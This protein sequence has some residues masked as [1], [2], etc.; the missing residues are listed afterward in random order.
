MPTWVS[1]KYLWVRTKTTDTLNGGG[2]NETVSPQNGRY[3]KNLTEAL[4]SAAGAASDASEAASVQQTIYRSSS[5]GTLPTAPS[6]WV[7]ANS[8]TTVTQD[9]V[10]KGRQ[11]VWTPVRPEYSSSY[12]ALY[13]CTQKQTVGGTVSCTT[14]R[15]DA[16][17]TVI[18]G[19][20]ILSKTIDADKIAVSDLSALGATIGGW[21]IE[22]NHLVKETDT[23]R[24]RFNAFASTVPSNNAIS[25]ATRAST[26][27]SWDTQ[28]SVSNAGTVTCK[29][30]SVQ[31]GTISIGGNFYV[32]ANG[33]LTA[34]T[35]SF[36]G[37]V[38][39]KNI[40]SGTIDGVDHGTFGGGGITS[41]SLGTAQ[42][43]S[44]INTSLGFA[45]F[46]DD[47]FNNR[48][49]A[50]YVNV[51]N[52]Y[53]NTYR[54][55][56]ASVTVNQHKHTVTVNDGTVSIGTPDWVGN[57]TTSFNIADTKFYKDAVASAREDGAASVNVS[58]VSIT[59]TG[60]STMGKY[61][62]V[63]VSLSNGTSTTR[64]VY[65]S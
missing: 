26:S 37:N 56:G 27:E 48:Q 25:V 28:F 2:T 49:T 64:I 3:D 29:N 21:S 18:D 24:I 31:G 51:A 1:G 7:E 43:A 9:G 35:G 59:R 53:A 47:V 38:S 13:V 23:Y 12:P 6:T 55:T 46:A 15:L 39:A 11:G 36:R 65:Y 8:T 57:G 16:T 42:L 61:A 30:I 50:S 33:D 17:T 5:G 20:H 62:Y 32:N 41:G 58:S 4:M 34:N 52:A 60:E 54:V 19:G 45:N 14:V 22:S 10:V 63:Q 40:Q 44:G